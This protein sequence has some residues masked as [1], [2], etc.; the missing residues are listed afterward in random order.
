MTYLRKISQK[1]FIT[2]IAASQERDRNGGESA[3]WKTSDFYCKRGEPRVK[4]TADQKDSYPGILA[5][6]DDAGS[7]EQ[8]FG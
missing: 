3:L 2:G 6:A 4:S 1:F 5:M 8:P 7:I